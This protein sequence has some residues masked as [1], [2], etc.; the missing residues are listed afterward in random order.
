MNP[1]HHDIE[2]RVEAAY[3]TVLDLN[4]TADQK[5]GAT[6]FTGMS[7]GMRT[8][9]RIVVTVPRC[10]G[11]RGLPGN[12]IA[13]VE[14][15]VRT[16]ADEAADFPEAILIDHRTRLAYVRDVLQD[17]TLASKL[18]EATPDLTVQGVK[19]EL[20]TTSALDSDFNDFVSVMTHEILCCPNQ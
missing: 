19:T 14:I 4:L 7:A 15:E 9:P 6:V 3:K 11:F 5:A 2:S 13:N 16:N 12:Y 10:Q 1:P 8:L 18:S 20:E 17:S